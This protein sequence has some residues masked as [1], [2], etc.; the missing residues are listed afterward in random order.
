MMTGRLWGQY[1]VGAISFLKQ[2]GFWLSV[3]TIPSISV[4]LAVFLLFSILVMKD[5][6]TTEAFLF[7]INE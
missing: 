7:R 1:T 5:F 2:M 4:Y 3:F 6:W